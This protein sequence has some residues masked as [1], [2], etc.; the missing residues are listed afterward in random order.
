MKDKNG[1]ER[2]KAGEESNA[3]F[4]LGEIIARQSAGYMCDSL[5]S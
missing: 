5:F 4:R 1:A 3:V 2:R